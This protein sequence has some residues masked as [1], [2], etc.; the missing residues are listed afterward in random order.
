MNR[1]RGLG[2][3]AALAA[4]ALGALGGPARAVKRDAAIRQLGVLLFDTEASWDFLLRDLPP[5]LALQGWEQ[6]RN[7]SLSW[8]FANGDAGRLPGLCARLLEAGCHT[9]LTRGTPCTRALQQATRT[10]P[11]VTGVGDPVG[12]GFAASLA[13]PGAN[14]TGLSYAQVET[15]AKQIELL[16]TLAP[17]LR[18]LLVIAPANRR[19]FAAEMSGPLERLARSLGLQVRALWPADAADL[20][21]ALRE[22]LDGQ[23]PGTTG[24]CVFSFGKLL[25]PAALAQALL[26]A[27]LPSAFEYRFYV[28]A[29]GLLSYRLNWTDQT[30]STARQLAK[31]LRGEDPAGIPFELP[32]RSELVINARTAAQLGLTV[33]QALRARA[34]EVIG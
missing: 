27:G 6:G 7:L 29:G 13:R 4:G 33:P 1:R 16:R 23:A 21:G 30:A 26:Q 31:V 28:E 24:A 2:S 8:Q 12:S 22:A 5:A 19:A 15:A 10:T 34:D 25:E 3:M 20:R 9:I 11:I 14:I 17:R 18:S 32:T